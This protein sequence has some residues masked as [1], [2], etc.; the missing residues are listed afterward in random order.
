MAAS[1]LTRCVG[2]WLNPLL[3]RAA[4]SPLVARSFGGGHPVTVL[5]DEEKMMKETVARFA[6]EKIQPLVREMDQRSEMDKSIING[7]FEH[8]LMCI[9]VDPKYGGAGSTFFSSI[10]AIEELAKVDPSVSVLCDVQN[11]LVSELFLRWGSEDLKNKYLPK[12]TTEMVGSYCL[13]EPS[14]GTDAFALKTSAK[15]EGGYWI[16]NG[17]KAWITNA[18]HAGV[19]MVMANI[20]FNKGYKGIT[21]FVVDKDSEGLTVGKKEDKLG[22]RA[23]STCPVFLEN[24]KVH[25]SQVI[26]ELG[27]GYKYAIETLNMGRIG[28]GAQMIGLAKG[29]LNA[30]IPYLHEREAFGQKIADFQA[31]QHMRAQLATDIEVAS[32]M[33]YNT[34][35]MHEQGMPY[36]KEAAMAKYFSSEVANRVASRCVEMVAGVGFT[37]EY[38]IEKFFRDAKIGQIYEGTSF[39]QLSTIAKCMDEEFKNQ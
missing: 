25:E 24:V 18:E 37:K 23:S 10:L 32:V 8:G 22:I 34:A 2:S 21:T 1:T 36:V 28:I 15:K 30:V 12:L 4:L 6:R 14:C 3:S 39:T 11:T 26:G 20:D 13:S 19:F 33:V 17:Q 29:A 38:P 9:E 27:K 16:L 35:R 5:S 31:M 7:L